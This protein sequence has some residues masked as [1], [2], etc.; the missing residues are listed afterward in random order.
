M[1]Q[2]TTAHLSLSPVHRLLWAVLLFASQRFAIAQDKHLVDSLEARLMELRVVNLELGKTEP[3]ILDSSTA[4]VLNRLGK[5]FIDADTARA[6]ACFKQ[7]LDLSERINYSLG[8]CRSLNNMASLNMRRSK[9]ASAVGQLERSLAVAEK[10]GDRRIVKFDLFQ[11]GQIR[12]LQGQYPEALHHLLAAHELFE[13]DGDSKE[14]AQVYNTLANVYQKVGNDREALNVL[15]SSLRIKEE[16][17]DTAGMAQ[18]HL[19]IGKMHYI[20]NNTKMAQESYEVALLFNQRRSNKRGIASCFREMSLLKMDDP[21]S[22]EALDLAHKALALDEEIGNKQGIIGDRNSI[23]LVHSRQGRHDLAVEFF[24]KA[25]ELAEETRDMNMVASVCKGLSSSYE[26]LGRPAQALEFHKRFTFLKDSLSNRETSRRIAELQMRHDFD[27][28]AAEARS[29]QA[30]K[31]LLAQE[32]IDRHKLVRNGFIGGFV[33]MVLFASVFLIQRN[34]IGREKRAGEIERQRS[35]ELLLNILPAEVAEELRRNG[36]CQP[37]TYSMATVLFADFKDFTGVSEKISA[38]LL[39]REIDACFKG[40]DAIIGKHRV[41]KIKTVGDAYMCA[42]GLPSLNYTHAKDMVVAALEMCAFML[43]RKSEKEARGEV[44]FELRIGV[45]TGPVV[46]GIVGS[47]K[48]AYDIWGDTVNI[49]S[50]MESSGE[51]GQVNIS[52]ATYALIRE[53]PGL[54]FV[55]RGK[56]LAKGKGELEMYFVEPG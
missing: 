56:V 52:E 41:E 7:E 19:N 54:R 32:D 49:A 29:E 5:A 13:D 20:L 14:L 11:L 30:Q 1:Q 12:Y 47:K 9:L 48:F 38:E 42:S 27:R 40:F 50:R 4:N 23:A 21:E 37:K 44:A 18:A 43:A 26:A 6:M 39:V 25:L 53:E 35:D 51:A 8:I 36:Q 55:P 24:A 3:S 34:R 10:I 33:L 31:D 45:H 28:Q 15:T 2:G 16:L 46:A 22:S 17:G